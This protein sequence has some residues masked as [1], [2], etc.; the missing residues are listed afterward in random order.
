MGLKIPL[1]KIQWNPCYRVIP[2]RDPPINVFDRVSD[3]DD[4]EALYEIEAM[5]NDRLRAEQ[6][7]LHLIPKSEWVMGP[8]ASFIMA[9]FLHLNP[10]GNRFSDGTFGIYYT[11]KKLD[12]ALTETKFH[13]EKFLRYTNEP[14]MHLEM[15]VL[16]AEL[17]ANLHDIRDPKIAPRGVY[18]LNSYTES[19][20]LGKRLRQDNSW[21]ILFK[22]VRDRKNKQNDCAA[23]F[24]PKALK[25]CQIKT[26]VIFR[27]DGER[28][29]DVFEER[30]VD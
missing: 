15:R 6:D 13:R 25:K 23:I 3:P 28:I 7:R 21:G 8:N 9:P 2:S 26:H 12:T 16:I 30:G 29:R 17:K 11:A 22:S 5:T 18:S 4:A 10:N 27:W 14:V 1:K 20:R 19:Q 24:R